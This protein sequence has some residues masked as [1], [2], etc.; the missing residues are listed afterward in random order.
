MMLHVRGLSYR[1][2]YQGHP[3]VHD[4]DYDFSAGKLYVLRGENGSGK[5]TLLQLLAGLHAADE[6]DILWQKKSISDPTYPQ[7]VL[8][9]GHHLGLSLNLTVHETLTWF[10]RDRSFKFEI[11][12]ASACR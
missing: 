7:Q 11:D 1:A 9:M 3:I 2:T 6:G 8:W 12:D 10:T 4:F 5:T